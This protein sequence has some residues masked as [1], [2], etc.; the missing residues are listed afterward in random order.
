MP[1]FESAI[2]QKYSGSVVGGI[3][4]FYLAEAVWIN[5]NK[6]RV[7]DNT[8]LAE[9]VRVKSAWWS[10]SFTRTKHTAKNVRTTA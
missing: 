6:V 5:Y 1:Y 3:A 9:S 2:L 4:Q 7:G 10:I 8:R